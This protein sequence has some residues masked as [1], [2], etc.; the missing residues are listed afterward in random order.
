MMVASLAFEKNCVLMKDA[1]TMS[2]YRYSAPAPYS[3]VFPV[4]RGTRVGRNFLG[5]SLLV[6]LSFLAIVSQFISTILLSDTGPGNIAGRRENVS[7]AY[8]YGDVVPGPSWGT[9]QD[10]PVNFPRFAEKAAKPFHISYNSTGPGISDTGPTVRSLF[11]LKAPQRSSLLYY[12][13]N[14][15]MIDSHVLCVSPTVD[16]LQCDYAGA[17]TNCAISGNFSAPILGDALASGQLERQGSF[18]R[19]ETRLSPIFTVE[20]GAG[21]IFQG[22]ELIIPVIPYYGQQ[23]R[24][25]DD[26]SFPG[27]KLFSGDS[28]GK[29]L[30][31]LRQTGSTSLEY[32]HESAKEN[33]SLIYSEKGFKFN[34]TEWTTKFVTTVQSEFIAVAI[35]LC[36]LKFNLATAEIE[37][38]ADSN[39][40]EPQYSTVVRA[41]SPWP[42]YNMTSLQNQLGVKTQDDQERGIF[43]LANYTKIKVYLVLRIPIA[44][45]FNAFYNTRQV[46]MRFTHP[47]YGSI[48]STMLNNTK[49]ASLA[50]QA[51]FTLFTANYYYAELDNYNTYSN[52]IVQTVQPVNIPTM[53]RGLFIVWGIIGIHFLSVGV[54]FWLY[55]K[56][57]APKFLNQAWQIVGQLH[58]GDAR[59]FLDDTGNLGDRAVGRLPSAAAMW[60]EPVKISREGKH[61]INYRSTSDIPLRPL[62]GMC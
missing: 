62:Q 58:S 40:T 30:L 4:L 23:F 3:M 42:D 41:S 11:P 17:G 60:E 2:I 56:S 53:M 36:Y 57:S 61:P 51:L 52:S 31:L 35:T 18:A 24:G 33:L 10:K 48:F 25:S 47:I 5:I 9:L 44:M 16:Q 55:F 28:Q 32:L 22:A 45:Q 27:T 6:L 38:K 7:L 37:V 21:D 59:E 49:T 19:N 43:D 1:A 12:Q 39:F 14:A 46:D 8:S 20:M 15:T 29:W 13:G 34:G 50:L 26:S 54:I